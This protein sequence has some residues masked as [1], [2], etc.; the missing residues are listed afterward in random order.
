MRLLVFL[1]LVVSGCT[2]AQQKD[3]GSPDGWVTS[4]PE[5][6]G[7]D[8]VGLSETISFIDQDPHNDFRS[9][10][11]ARNG[12]LVSEH[13]FNG[14]GP[15]SLQDVRSA[16]KSLTSA[17]IGI[18][19]SEEVVPAIDARVLSLFPSYEP[20]AHD[21]EAKRTITVEHLL[22]MTSGLDANA[23][24]PDTPGYEDRMWE[25]EDWVRFV[26][27]LPMAHTPGETWSYASANTFLLG[28]AVEEVA[29][30]TL[31]EYAE[32]RLFGPL[33][34]TRYHWVETPLGRTVAQGNLSIRARDMAKFGQLYLNG[35]RWGGQQ[36]V[37]ES[38]VRRS[39]EGQYP[40]PWQ[41]YDHYG[42]GWYSHA[43]RVGTRTFQYFFASGNGGNKI[44]VFPEE[45]MVVVIQ[46]AAYN[47]TYGQRRSLEVLKRVLAAV[48]V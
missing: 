9:L 23:D 11:V 1:L 25:S 26:L 31:A 4:Q 17:L 33:G 36:I 48:A 13:Y 16:T 37:P 18:A 12:K 15:D 41:G 45:Q 22:T 42:Y 46:S 34:I 38:W 32:G 47:T 8:P 3:T 6:E 10:L 5:T 27:D 2:T 24:D 21:G 28:A 40:V 35:G 43:L 7:L 39:V 30:Q 29:G 44:Y 14:H 20:V 19:I